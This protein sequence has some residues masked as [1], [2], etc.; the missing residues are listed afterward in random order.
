MKYKV[1]FYTRIALGWE[2]FEQSYKTSEEAET[3]LDAIANY[4]L[5]LHDKNLMPDHSNTGLVMKFEDS[6]W[7]EID[8]DEVEI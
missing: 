4:T 5:Y 3:A 2:P 6:E 1:V 7:V 8:S